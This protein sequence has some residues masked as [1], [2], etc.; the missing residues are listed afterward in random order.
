M[1]NKKN[2]N[3]SN[4]IHTKYFGIAKSALT[5][6]IVIESLSLIACLV[7]VLGL[8]VVFTGLLVAIA[9]FIP[10]AGIFAWADSKCTVERFKMCDTKAAANREK[11]QLFNTLVELAELNSPT[12]GISVYFGGGVIK[13]TPELS[14]IPNYHVGKTIIIPDDGTPPVEINR[15]NIQYVPQR[16][17]EAVMVALIKQRG[18]RALADK[19]AVDILKAL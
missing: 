7:Y 3:D 4:A 19:A 11:F 13:Y 6:T 9:G 15:D 10:A 18:D 8:G 5:V 17:V 14:T 16:V 12:A 2:R 1:K